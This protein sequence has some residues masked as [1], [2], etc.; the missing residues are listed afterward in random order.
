VRFTWLPSPIAE[1]H[2]DLSHRPDNDAVAVDKLTRINTW[3]ASQMAA[4]MTKMKAVPEGDGTLLD[5]TLILWANELAIG[6]VHSRTD[7]PYVL[8]GGAGGTLRTGRFLTYP[9]DVPHNN[10][11]VSLFNL[12]GDDRTTFGDSRC[13]TGALPNLV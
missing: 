5:H 4:L 11:L 7:A 3:Y 1:A 8:G 12:F 9:G 2:H 6:N 13:C 10:L